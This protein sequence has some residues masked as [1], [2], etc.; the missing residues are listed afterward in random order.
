M[1]YNFEKIRAASGLGAAQVRVPRR[2][3]IVVSRRN[4]TA[5]FPSPGTAPVHGSDP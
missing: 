3:L 5:Q 4:S 1:K 2:C